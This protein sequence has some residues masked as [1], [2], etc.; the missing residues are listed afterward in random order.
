MPPVQ[1]VL[2]QGDVGVH[3]EPDQLLEAGLRLPAELGP[4]LG[5]IAAQLVDLRGPVVGGVDQDVAAPVQAGV[6]EGDLA[7]LLDGVAL[8]RRDHV[9][10]GPVLLQHPPHRLDVLGGV[11]P[12]PAGLQVAEVQA[13]L[14]ARLDAGDGPGDLAGDERLPPPGALMVEQDAVDRIQAVGLPV[15]HGRPV[16]VDLGAAVGAAWMERGQLVLRRRG[17][18]EHLRRR[19]LVEPRLHARGADRLQ[20]PGGAKAGRLPGVLGDLERHLHVALGAQVVD[21]VGG[22][23]PDQIDQRHRVGQ[24]A[25]VQ[26]QARHRLVRVLVDV[27]EPTGVER[28]GTPDDAMDLVALAKQQLGQVGAVLPGDARDKG[29][30][31]PTP[32]DLVR[33]D[34]DERCRYYL[35]PARAA[36]VGRR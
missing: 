2:E 21:L 32:K 20:Q 24:V 6:G 11:A 16:G 14:Q 8:P 26:L 4:G 9:V 19:R 22:D 36:N 12:V 23:G 30:P 29:A 1:L 31:H 3:H 25:V 28:R 18:P 33:L 27:I 5:G 35:R 34:S 17:R 10:V 15:V 13:V 7:E